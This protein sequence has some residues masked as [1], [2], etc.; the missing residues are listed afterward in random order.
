[1]TAGPSVPIIAFVWLPEVDCSL[2]VERTVALGSTWRLSSGE[3]P[4]E[5]PLNAG[6]CELP[7]P[8]DADSVDALESVAE[9]LASSTRSGDDVDLDELTLPV[10]DEVSADP[11]RAESL[12]D[13]SPTDGD[14]D[15][16]ESALL[17]A[18]EDVVDADGSTRLPSVRTVLF[19]VL[20][21]GELDSDVLAVLVVDG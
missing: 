12:I 8:V 3:S 2:V 19:G 14:L 7:S 16:R 10:I 15:G 5:E 11:P 1:M 9:S 6:I 4:P 20:T 21:V 13:V 17:I 18:G